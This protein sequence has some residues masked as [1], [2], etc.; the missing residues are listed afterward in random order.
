[1]TDRY[2]YIKTYNKKIYYT[3]TDN[4]T[5]GYVRVNKSTI[6]SDLL[7]DIKEKD[8]KI[9]IILLT[10]KLNSLKLKEAKLL[11]DLNVVKQQ[12]ISQQE[13]IKKNGGDYEEELN[14]QKKYYNDKGTNY[15]K[16]ND[17]FNSNYSYYYNHDKSNNTSQ[18]PKFISDIDK[19]INTLYKN[20]IY[21]K[22][23][24]KLNI[25]DLK[26]HKYRAIW[27]RWLV[28]NHPDRGGSN[29]I[30][31]DVIWAGKYMGW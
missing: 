22:D 4:N 3:Y 23:E 14:R 26:N 17:Y 21:T 13:K 10:R 29:S 15:K 16:F 7:N 24:S 20:N 6:S 30:C 9:D 12:I 28:K 2:F 5:S 8:D 1:M 25:S 31:Q 19:A 11:D 27:R 18:Q